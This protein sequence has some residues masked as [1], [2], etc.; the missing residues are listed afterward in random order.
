MNKT[1]ETF[2]HIELKPGYSDDD[3]RRAIW[4]RL[5]YIYGDIIYY[6]IADWTY[7]M[8]RSYNTSDGMIRIPIMVT[9]TREDVAQA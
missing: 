4:R 3:F 8:T 1:Q 5:E 6:Y 9:L 7:D 2:F